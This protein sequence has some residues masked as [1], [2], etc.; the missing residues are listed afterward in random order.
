MIYTLQM[1]LG[2]A[3]AGRR[4]VSDSITDEKVFFADS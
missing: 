1:F 3:V 4:Y 2:V